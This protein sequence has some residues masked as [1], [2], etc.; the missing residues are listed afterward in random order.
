MDLTKLGAVIAKRRK[1]FKM[2]QKDLAEKSGVSHKKIC[3]IEANQA[4]SDT[5]K[6]ST[7]ELIAEALYITPSN[8]LAEIEPQIEEDEKS[9]ADELM[10]VPKPYPFGRIYS[11]PQIMIILPILS[12]RTVAE[13]LC[14]LGGSIFGYEGYILDLLN[15]RYEDAPDS[16]AKRYAE[17]LLSFID[18]RKWLMMPNQT[19]SGV[20]SSQYFEYGQSPEFKE[21]RKA[22]LELIGARLKKAEMLESYIYNIERNLSAKD[23][24]LGVEIT[25]NTIIDSI[26]R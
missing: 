9:E 8:L 13:I 25:I 18:E 10:Y 26:R 17:K 7:L 22:Y 6:L 15:N 14:R 2:T 23:K 12:E 11:V 24:Y 4:K 3:E 21:E 1:L 20:L 5:I 16:P 19:P